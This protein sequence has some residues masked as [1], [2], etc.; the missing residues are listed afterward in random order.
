MKKNI[1][2]ILLGIALL[3]LPLLVN[4]IEAKAGG[5]NV[6][7]SPTNVPA[8]GKVTCTIKATSGTLS[9]DVNWSLSDSKY[10]ASGSLKKGS[11]FQGSITG[12]YKS[13]RAPIYWDD[14]L[15]NSGA[16]VA[17]ITLNIAKRVGSFQLKVNGEWGDAD[18]ETHGVSKSV[19]IN[20]ITTTTKSTLRTTTKST[21]KTVRTSGGGTLSTSG[22][23]LNPSST[24]MTYTTSTSQTFTSPTSGNYTTR[25]GKSNYIDPDP[26]HTTSIDSGGMVHYQ[27]T[28]PDGSYTRPVG[29]TQS[30]QRTTGKHVEPTTRAGQGNQGGNGG[31]G[32]STPNSGKRKPANAGFLD[33]AFGGPTESTKKYF[34]GDFEH[35]NDMGEAAHWSTTK[36]A[37]TTFGLKE[38]RVLTDDGYAK[39]YEINGIYY[40][41]VDYAYEV[42]EVSAVTKGEASVYGTGQRAL[43]VGKNLVQLRVVNNET[44]EVLVYQLV[45]IR[46]DGSGVHDTS[47]RNLEV[48]GFDIDFS[49]TITEYTLFVPYTMS[50]F[51]ISAQP[52]NEDNIVLGEGIY[53]LRKDNKDNIIYVSCSYGDIQTTQYAIHIKRSYRSIIPWVIVFLLLAGLIGL[54]IYMQ[55]SKK[56]LQSDMTAEKDKEVVAAKKRALV[57]S[58][59]VQN[60]KVNGYNTN[61]VGR[62]TVVPTAVPSGQRPT[63]PNGP[64]QPGQPQRPGQPLQTKP[65]PG[66]PRR[67]VSPEESQNIL[68]HKVKPKYV[69]PQSVSPQGNAAP[70]GVKTLRTVPANASGPYHEESVVVTNLNK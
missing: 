5:V 68:E 13:G 3:V 43:T 40:S 21:T 28:G 26:N 60:M 25:S 47:L 18:F 31:N 52:N 38:V 37:D 16:T 32:A 50:K 61:D 9:L 30:V 33:E 15:G 14:P 34:L 36:K 63:P 22:R 6:S 56:K 57:N 45:I 59:N 41:T 23:T 70:G 49:P 7:C 2:K 10:V 67:P 17:T 64:Q 24:H 62:R 35:Q 44:A 1:R 55:I 69:T 12:D 66:A 11:G 54:V 51:Y 8:S 19:T 27:T 58:Q 20:V 39:V 4:P 46:D 42:V 29:S 53:T 48:V 65:V